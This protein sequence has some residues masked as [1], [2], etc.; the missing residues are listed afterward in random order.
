MPASPLN[1]F[2]LKSFIC[3]VIGHRS[4]AQKLKEVTMLQPEVVRA[5][6]YAKLHCTFKGDDID[7]QYISWTKCLP[8]GQRMLVYEYSLCPEEDRAYGDLAGRGQGQVTEPVGS[9]GYAPTAHTRPRRLPTVS[10]KLPRDMDSSSVF[11]SFSGNRSAY[12]YS[13]D[14]DVYHSKKVGEG[15]AILKISDVMLKDEGTY[16][17]LVKVIDVAPLSDVKLQTVVGKHNTLSHEQNSLSQQGLQQPL[18][19]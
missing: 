10:S 7:V 11:T 1:S 15:S 14:V 8:D 3:Y 12:I 17:C 18:L 19:Y 13:A 2:H 4:S 5:G 9:N 6:S 16:E